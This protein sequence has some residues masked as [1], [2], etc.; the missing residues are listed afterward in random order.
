MTQ[1]HY[2]FVTSELLFFCFFCLVSKSIPLKTFL[3]LFY[4]FKSKLFRKS[5]KAFTLH[6][7]CYFV[8]VKSPLAVIFFTIARIS[9]GFC[10]VFRYIAIAPTLLHFIFNYFN[11][12]SISDVYY[13]RFFFKIILFFRFCFCFWFQFLFWIV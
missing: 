6:Y 13:N 1:N 10:S 3:N 2:F 11:L 9:K 4:F 12:V 7:F 8:Y 5:L